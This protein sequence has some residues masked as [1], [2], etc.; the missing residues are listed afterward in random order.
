MLIKDMFERDIDRNINGVVTINENDDKQTRALA[1]QELSEYVVTEELRGH[2]DTFLSAYTRAFDNPTGK[3]GVWI[4][5]FFGSGKSHFLK[6]LS[7]LLSGKEA[8]GKKAIDYLSPRFESPHISHMAELACSVPTETILF[9]IDS[10]GPSQ[11]DDTAV[12]KVFAR[13]FYEHLGFFGNNLKLARLERMIASRGKTE[14]FRAAFQDIMGEVWENSRESY[15]FFGD[16]VAE[17]M[18]RAGVTS[19]ENALRWIEGDDEV[20]FSVDSLTDE[21]AAYAKRRAEEEG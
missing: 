19:K 11:K 2:F 18:E 21:I 12:L 3:M 16:E 15:D 5:G 14:Q 17:A 1:I 13:V 7:Y 10:K 8:G 9:N 20:D 4:S 6:M